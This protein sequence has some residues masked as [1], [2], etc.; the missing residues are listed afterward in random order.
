VQIAE[1]KQV[2]ALNSSFDTQ[3]CRPSCVFKRSPRVVLDRVSD[4]RKLDQVSWLTRK[5]IPVHVPC[6][7]RGSGSLHI[8]LVSEELAIFLRDAGVSTRRNQNK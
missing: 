4:V 8:L 3:H 1:N 6:I 7:C 5:K 2:F